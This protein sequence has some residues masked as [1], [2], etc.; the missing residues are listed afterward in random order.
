MTPPNRQFPDKMGKLGVIEKKFEFGLRV[1]YNL[2]RLLP[3]I[4]SNV[5]LTLSLTALTIAASVGS[6]C[7]AF[8]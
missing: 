7:S 4:Y 6:Q 5:W 2:F 3:L 8:F 1:F